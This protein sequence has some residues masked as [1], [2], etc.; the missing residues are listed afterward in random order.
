MTG[1]VVDFHH[2]TFRHRLGVA[3]QFVDVFTGAVVRSPLRVRLP[4]LGLAARRAPDDT[5]RLIVPEPPVP[6]PPPA[7]FEVAVEGDDYLL[8]DGP[9]Q[10]QL[11]RSP[12]APPP[13][14]LRADYLVR[15]VL[16][17]TT[18]VRP[19]AGETAVVG[20]VVRTT[21]GTPIEGLKV[22]IH[23]ASEDPAL[24]PYTRTD[25]LG[26]FLYRLSRL[27]GDASGG[28]PPSNVTLSVKMFAPTGPPLAPAPAVL[29][30]DLGRVSTIAFTVP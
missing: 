27:Q 18:R 29:A 10:V 15:L 22:V 30:V 2:V 20:S 17:P 12:S 21:P 5:Y 16:W 26:Q 1:A 13:P 7:L 19:P 9:L 3:L 14:A 28:T 4:A 8:L 6:A 24:M 23:S 25:A 11:P